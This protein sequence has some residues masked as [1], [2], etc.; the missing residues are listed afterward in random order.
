M[1]LS[2]KQIAPLV[3]GTVS[4]DP[5]KVICGVAPFEDARESDITLAAGPAYLKRLSASRAGAF[6]I[7][8]GMAPSGANCLQVDH[9]MVAFARVIQAFHP[10]RRPPPGIHPL[11][12][13]GEGVRVGEAVSIGPFAVVGNHVAIGARVQIGAATVVGD[14]ASLGDDVCLH[15][16]VTI[17]DGCRI[18]NRVVIHSGTV[19]GSD[20]FGF[21]PDGTAY[22]KIPQ[23]GIVQI[24]DDVEIGANNTIDRATFGKTWI[25]RG[26]K[27]DNLVHIAHNV[28]I[29]ENTVI[30]AQVGISG[31]VSIGSN[32]ILAGQAGISG[33]LSIGDGATVGPSSGVI[34]SVAPGEIVVGTP[35][36]P[37]MRQLRVQAVVAKL[38]EMKKRLNGLEKAVAELKHGDGRPLRRETP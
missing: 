22:H 25:G 7:A 30:V 36:M 8:R 14:D 3:G 37:R 12:C 9:P 31:S 4:G 26:V 17:R 27:T 33:H 32:V 29:G 13:I 20:G 28:T 6:I 24:D 38:P 35:A 10:P 21:A 34:K 23:T 2:L 19:I 11:A 16:Q 18:G 1:E 15:P 5:A